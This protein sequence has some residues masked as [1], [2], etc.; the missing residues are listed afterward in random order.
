MSRAL[1][2]RLLAALAVF[3]T[4]GAAAPADAKGRRPKVEWTIAVRAGRDQGEKEKLLEK[5]LK[6]E[7]RHA[8]WG[9][10][11]DGPVEASIEIRE[12][13]SIVDG[14]VVRV[15]CAGVGR[16][17]GVGAAK[18]KFSFGGRPSERAK[19][20]RHV[21]ELVAR[22]IVTRLAEMARR[23]RGPWTVEKTAS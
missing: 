14:D 22:G 2:V 15:T 6:R 20:E 7:A 5:L 18:S 1:F 4:L 17:P 19:L 8:D 10:A 23:R 16:I 3:A 9:P 13:V 11:G 21:L 12:L